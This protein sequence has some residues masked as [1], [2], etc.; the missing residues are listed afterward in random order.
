MG[1]K[2]ARRQQLHVDQY[3]KEIGNEEYKKTK[4]EIKKARSKALAKDANWNIRDVA[5]ISF[6]MLVLV[7]A[8]YGFF[9]IYLESDPRS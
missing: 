5:M 3:R 9:F 2:D 7:F 4:K 1:R 8:V 6:A